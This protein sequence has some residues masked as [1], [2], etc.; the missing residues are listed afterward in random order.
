GRGVFL[1]AVFPVGAQG[2]RLPQA[3][4]AVDEERI[5]AVP[6]IVGHGDGGRVGELVSRPD[7]EAVERVP[8][9][10]QA[11]TGAGARGGLLRKH[12]AGRYCTRATR[13]SLLAT[14]R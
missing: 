12:Q 3:A 8:V 9:V 2:R 14:A 6:R 10:Q 5:V 11:E 13:L 4:P 1:D 7:D